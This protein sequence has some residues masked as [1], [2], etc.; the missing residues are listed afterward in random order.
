MLAGKE[1][2]RDCRRGGGRRGERIIWCKT[3]P[4]PIRISHVDSRS[5]TTCTEKCEVLFITTCKDISPLARS[6]VESLVL[7]VSNNIS[8]MI[9]R[10]HSFYNYLA[11]LVVL[12]VAGGLASGTVK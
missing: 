5:G 1:D 2:S 11:E 4:R 10:A 9:L 3:C 6:L 12:R 7:L 8:S